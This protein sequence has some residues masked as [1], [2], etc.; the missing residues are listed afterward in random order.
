MDS[1]IRGFH[2]YSTVWAPVLHEQLYS[3]QDHGN[4]R[5]QF[6]VALVKTSTGSTGPPVTVGHVPKEISR[7]CWYFIQ[8]DGE[9]TCEVTGVDKRRSPL[10]QGGMEIPCKLT[11]I[12]KKKHI[13]KVKKIL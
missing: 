11:F 3:S 4:T 2:V 5:D 6:A 1:A 10:V 9:I 12:G 8:H 7:I 13:K